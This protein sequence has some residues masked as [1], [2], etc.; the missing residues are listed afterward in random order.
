MV[1]YFWDSYAVAELIKG[2]INYI[3]YSQEPLIFTI[4]NLIEIYW[5]ALRIWLK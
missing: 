3:K 5:F 4:F 2:N 1:N